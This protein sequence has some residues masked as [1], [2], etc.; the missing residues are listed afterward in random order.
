MSCTRLQTDTNKTKTTNLQRCTRYMYVHTTKYTTV[1]N[2]AEDDMFALL[3]AVHLP[4][5]SPQGTN[6]PGQHP[7]HTTTTPLWLPQCPLVHLCSRQVRVHSV[8]WITC[9][10]WYAVCSKY[11]MFSHYSSIMPPRVHLCSVL[12]VCAIL[13]ERCIVC[14]AYHA[15]CSKCPTTTSPFRQQEGSLPQ[16]WPAPVKTSTLCCGN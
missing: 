9:S 12:C 3:L 2:A 14:N 4:G 11:P 16:F 10:A 6:Y 13:N 1:T 8:W 15:L 7:P 5:N